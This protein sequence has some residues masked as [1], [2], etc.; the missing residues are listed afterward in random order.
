MATTQ[1]MSDAGM[2]K[3]L[4]SALTRI[5]EQ[6]SDDDGKLSI[7]ADELIKRL[8]TKTNKK[9]LVVNSRDPD[10]PKRPKSAYFLWADTARDEMRDAILE[11]DGEDA[12]VSASEVAKLLGA[13]WKEMSDAEKAPFQEQA[14]TLSSEWKEAMAAYRAEKGIPDPVKYEKFDASQTPRAPS[15]WKKATPGYLETAPVDPETGKKVTKGFHD[16]AEAVAEAERIGAGGITRTR[17]GFKLRAG[18]EVCINSSSRAK[19]EMSWV[20]RA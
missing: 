15:G 2:G 19:G 8:S 10:M 14:N 18:N 3:R 6:F 1:M 16:F 5:M 20:R 11:E 4:Q 7:P 17:V 12:K 9:Q 13:R